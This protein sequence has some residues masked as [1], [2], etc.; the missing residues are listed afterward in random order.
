MKSRDLD[1]FQKCI[2]ETQSFLSQLPETSYKMQQLRYTVDEINAI[3][4]MNIRKFT[5]V[6][7]STMHSHYVNIFRGLTR[8]LD[9]EKELP[10]SVDDIVHIPERGRWWL[11]GSAWLPSASISQN[12][13]DDKVDEQTLKFSPSLLQLAKRAKMNTAVRRDI[14]CTIMSSTVSSYFLSSLLTLFS[15]LVNSYHFLVFCTF[16]FKLISLLFKLY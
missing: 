6:I 5:D 16:L 10:M 9:K 11:I 4:N 1:A 12:K 3:K 2:T 15:M 7:D 13:T 8:K 14:F